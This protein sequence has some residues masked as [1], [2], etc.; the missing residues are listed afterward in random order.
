MSRITDLPVYERRAEVIDAKLYN[1]WR[2]AKLHLPLPIKI[3]LSYL[4]GMM[5]I[6]EEQEWVCVD[7]RQNELPVI[8]WVDFEDKGRS[9]LH[10]QVACHLNYYHYAASML[11]AKVLHAM[12]EELKERLREKE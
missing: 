11:R 5:L 1:L 7:T 8:A 3:K 10:A 12:Q 2:R 6:L 9:S 4:T